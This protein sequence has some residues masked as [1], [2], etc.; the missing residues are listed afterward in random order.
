MNTFNFSLRALKHPLSLVSIGLLLLNDQVLKMAAPSWLTGKLS[1]FAG[2][3]FFPFL[4]ICLLSLFRLA[5]NAA[6]WTAFGL[7]AVWFA[8]IK[9]VPFANLVTESA[10]SWLTGTP[11]HIALEPS[12]LMALI[13]LWPAWL[14]WRHV[15]ALGPA[16]EKRPGW[17]AWA[18]LAIGWLGTVATSCPPILSVKRL[19]V[20]DTTIYARAGDEVSNPP[21]FKSSDGGRTWDQVTNAASN[22]PDVVAMLNTSVSS[23]YQLCNPQIPSACY[24]IAGAERVEESVDGDQHWQTAWEVPWGRR[25][26][27]DRRLKGGLLAC[28]KPSVDM[29]PYDLAFVDTAGHR[30]LVVAMGNEGVLLR[31]SAVTWE[32]IGVSLAHPTPFYG[33]VIDLVLYTFPETF[34]SLLVAMGALLMLASVTWLTVIRSKRSD[35]PAGRSPAWAIRPAMGVL[36]FVILASACGVNTFGLI[37]SAHG[38]EDFVNRFTVGAV[39]IAL[40][41]WPLSILAVV[42]LGVGYFWTWR[43][44]IPIASRPEFARRAHRISWLAALGLL[45][46]LPLPFGLW[47]VGII[48]LYQIAAVLALLVGLVVVVWGVRTVLRLSRQAVAA[49][50]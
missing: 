35:P 27:M 31:T 15:A 37:G 23:L 46:L 32:R 12:D 29:G 34:A 9:T 45:G 19:A 1:D 18:V 17:I 20:V 8:G 21:V 33:N 41:S 2:L 44:V 13:S 38:Y 3:F 14:L 47:V 49:G 43:R 25:Q 5:P 26:Y 11:S 24:R 30:A 48:P 16:V 42:S 10:I 22:L 50:E 6:G 28:R 7:T 40:E 39:V 4:L 36:L